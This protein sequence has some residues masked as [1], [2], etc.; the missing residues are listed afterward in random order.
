IEFRRAQVAF[1]QFIR[2]DDGIGRRKAVNANA[3]IPEGA[4]A[5]VVA[6][7]DGDRDVSHWRLQWPK[8]AT[9]LVIERLPAIIAAG[10]APEGATASVGVEEG[11][12][13]SYRLRGVDLA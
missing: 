6:R 11:C 8:G 10:D 4:D 5:V 7:R 12:K 1:E 2:L 13:L 9:C 3:A